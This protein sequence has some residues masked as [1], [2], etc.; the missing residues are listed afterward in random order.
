MDI[1]SNDDRYIHV[2]FGGA[3]IDGSFEVWV[4]DDTNLVDPPTTDDY[5]EW[6]LVME[7]VPEGAVLPAGG[8]EG[9]VLTKISDDNYDVAWGIGGG[10]SGAGLDAIYLD[11]RMAANPTSLYTE[12]AGGTGDMAY[13]TT[14]DGDGEVNGYIYLN[15]FGSGAFWDRNDGHDANF[16]DVLVALEVEWSPSMAATPVFSFSFRKQADRELKVQCHG[17]NIHI[18]STVSGADTL[19]ANSPCTFGGRGWIVG[20]VYHDFITAH[21]TQNHPLSK[22]FGGSQPSGSNNVSSTLSSDS[23]WN[24]EARRTGRAD[25]IRISTGSSGGSVNQHR[26]LR[27]LIVDLKKLPP[28]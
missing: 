24:T 22:F 17:T 21:W 14:T 16:R 25:R 1:S 4:S 13:D 23:N 9:D 26:I 19:R 20:M 10:G 7:G 15:A 8:I 12:E 6:E 2:F 18:Y 27:H 11:E 28:I 3:G 5:V